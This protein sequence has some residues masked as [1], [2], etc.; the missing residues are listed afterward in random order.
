MLSAPPNANQVDAS[1]IKN[2][3]QDNE[4][5]QLFEKMLMIKTRQAPDNGACT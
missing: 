2:E 3:D 4:V 1:G 5:K